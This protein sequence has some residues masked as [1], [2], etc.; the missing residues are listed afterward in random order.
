M[1]T[2]A[3]AAAIG[4]VRMCL[5]GAVITYSTQ[6]TEGHARP[7]PNAPKNGLLRTAKTLSAAEEKNFCKN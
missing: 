3:K 2:L 4:M 6:D 7:V 1:P 5:Q